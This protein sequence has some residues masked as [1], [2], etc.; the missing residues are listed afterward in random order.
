[1]DRHHYETFEKFGNDTFIIHLD[2]GRGFGKHSHDELS[3]LVPVIQCCRVRKSTYLR[4]QLLAKEEYQ[5]SSL[6]E[7]SLI[8]DRLSPVLLQRHL[9]A[10]DRRL[11]RVLQVLAGCIEKEGYGNVVDEDLVGNTATHRSPGHR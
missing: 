7:E 1:M 9:Q 11:R 8:R 6:M 3:I 10:M 2:N 5:L 4:L